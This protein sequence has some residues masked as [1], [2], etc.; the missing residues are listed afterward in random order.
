MLDLTNCTFIIPVRIDS[1]DRAF[2]FEYVVNYLCRNLKTNIIIFEQDNFQK[3]GQILKRINPIETKI[4]YRFEKSDDPIFHRTRILNEMLFDVKTKVVVNYDTDVLLKPE[5]YLK[6][7]NEILNGV[8]LC[9][10]YFFGESQKQI[11]RAN[12]F[13]DLTQ[14]QTTELVPAQAQYGHCQFFNTESYKA[15]GGENEYF[16]GWGPED[17]ERCFRAQKLG[18]SVKWLDGCEVFHIEHSRGVNSG[19][20][21]PHFESLEKIFEYIKSLTPE[22]LRAYY[23]NPPYLNKYKKKMITLLT[24]ADEN[25]SRQQEKLVDRALQLDTVDYYITMNRSD[26]IKT[27]FYKENKELLDQPRGS[28]Y[29][30]WKPYLI[31]EA[32]KT[33]E[34][35]D[36]LV[37]L[38]SGDWITRSFRIFVQ[39][40]M[41]NKDILLTEGGFPN[42]E[43]TKYNVLKEMGCLD[44]KFTEAIQVEAGIIVCKNTK[45]TQEIINEW[46]F[47]C[48]K[49]G[50]VD[51]SPSEERFIDFVDHRHDQ[52]VLSLLQVF[53]NIPATQEMRTYIN[54]NQNTN[55]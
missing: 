18:Y 31:L 9:Y 14:P 40:T 45:A 47:W 1:M 51:D 34:P 17:Q 2:N 43:Y 11:F 15:M 29:W 13:C 42:R 4:E 27:D 39:R 50:I 19:R 12:M 21:N 30:I 52:S 20:N 41:R 32:L 44:K 49:P 37:Y 5:T 22:A 26:L 3:A 48:L 35:D 54:C 38:D 36:I 7:Y 16:L 28:G 53:H 33:M 23:T 25:Y 8:D 6:A 24:Y 10:P 55:D 46:L